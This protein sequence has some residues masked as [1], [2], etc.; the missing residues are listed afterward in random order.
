[1]PS[2]IERVRDNMDPQSAANAIYEIMLLWHEA[3]ENVER[4]SHSSRTTIRKW[5]AKRQAY[6]ECLALFI[7]VTRE[8]AQAM[9]RSH[10]GSGVENGRDSRPLEVAGDNR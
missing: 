5:Q 1:M 6:E 10:Y 9:L 4:I 2:I 8:D 7:G 3:N